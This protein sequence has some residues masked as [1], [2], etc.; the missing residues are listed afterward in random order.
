MDTAGNFWFKYGY[1]EVSAKVASGLG[2]GSGFWLHGDD[3]I[4][5]SYAEYDIVEIYGDAKYNR[6]SPMAHKRVS[7]SELQSSILKNWNLSLS[8]YKDLMNTADPDKVNWNCF[9]LDI[10]N[11]ESF[12]DSFH[13][14][15]FE[16]DENCYSFILDGEVIYTTNY[17]NNG[18]P[19]QI[20]SYQSPVS[21]IISINCGNFSWNQYNGR[22]NSD[23]SDNNWEN[24][25]VYTVDYF[26]VY[27]KEG[28]YYSSNKND[29]IFG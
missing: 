9:N 3:T 21:A 14:F 27:Q 8:P 12:A 2:F 4:G 24:D 6:V 17:A 25:N 26:T 29:S 15:G 18:T 28:Q 16:W 10:A 1:T 20:A 19:E 13:T 7:E 23:F 22:G 11:N 5:N